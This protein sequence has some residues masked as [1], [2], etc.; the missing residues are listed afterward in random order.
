MSVLLLLPTITFAAPFDA[1]ARPVPNLNAGTP[2]LLNIITGI[3]GLL[4]VLFIAFAVIMFIVAGFFF[5]KAQ[6]EPAEL[7]TARKALLWGMIGVVVGIIA[8]LLPFI[9]RAWIV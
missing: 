9:I 5:L 7:V 2:W 4:W 8:F 1:G 6:G 3:I